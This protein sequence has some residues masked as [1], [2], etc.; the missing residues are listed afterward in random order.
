MDVSLRY[1]DDAKVYV[2]GVP[3]EEAAKVEG[4]IDCGNFTS[5]TIT[6]GKVTIKMF[7]DKED[8]KDATT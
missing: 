6:I 4:A 7:V 3:E 1:S 2:H 5:H 8:G